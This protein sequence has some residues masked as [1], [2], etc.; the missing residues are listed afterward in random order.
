MRLIRIPSGSTDRRLK[1]NQRKPR[2]EHR[3]Q[4]S[5][6]EGDRHTIPLFNRQNYET[7]RTTYNLYRLD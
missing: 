2:D 3:A 5:G 6:K 4:L 7:K 1:M